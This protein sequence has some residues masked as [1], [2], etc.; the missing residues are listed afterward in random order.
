MKSKL[1]A[2]AVGMFFLLAV[3]GC[4]S[5]PEEHKGAAVG[6]ATGA[7]V[8]AAAGAAIGDDTSGTIVGGLLGALIG[9]AIGHYYYDRKRTRAETV[10][11]YGYEPAGGTL[12][13]VENALA[14]PQ[15][16]KAGETVNLKM[17]YA[18]LNPS[19]NVKTKVTE[20]RE[21]THG[22]SIVG[23]PEVHVERYDG[24]YTSTIPITLPAGA[25]KGV[26][27]VKNIV[28]S[29]TGQDR[30]ETSFVVQ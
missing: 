12:L 29:A 13:T 20:V 8:G 27:Y 21:V 23:S 10:D 19:P 16:V 26:Y 9:G 18:V 14:T 30:K 6:A 17:T 4:A 22:G 1:L 7:A 15:T 2:A 25:D 5:I 11:T 24:T 28:K 3:S